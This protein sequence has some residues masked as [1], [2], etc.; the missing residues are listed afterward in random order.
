MLKLIKSPQAEEDLI[1]IW[2]YI[3]DDQPENADRWLD[4][5]NEA[6]IRLAETPGM[7]TER[8]VLSAGLKSFPVGSYVLYY[9]VNDG[10]LELAR[11]LPASRDVDSIHW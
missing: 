11:V 2:L 3:A 4:R 6:A 7:G 5:L 10:H 1:D 8:P 9:R